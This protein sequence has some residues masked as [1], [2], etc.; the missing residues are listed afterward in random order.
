MYWTLETDV[1]LEV[2]HDNIVLQFSNEDI[3]KTE[4]R[5]ELTGQL[6]Y[7]NHGEREWWVLR[8]LRDFCWQ[9]DVTLK[10]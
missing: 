2:V 1:L 8:R 4:N 6:S 7:L 5:T 9:F 3:A 10:C